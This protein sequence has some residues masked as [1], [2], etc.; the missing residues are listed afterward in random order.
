MSPVRLFRL[1]GVFAA[2]EVVA[3][4]QRLPRAK[5]WLYVCF[6]LRF[7]HAYRS[8]FRDDYGYGKLTRFITDRAKRQFNCVAAQTSADD[9]WDESSAIVRRKKVRSRSRSIWS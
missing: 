7:Y 6:P 9:E 2:A 5:N 3:W 4:S 1:R 8:R